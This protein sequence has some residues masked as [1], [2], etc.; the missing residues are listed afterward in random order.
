M[1]MAL[2]DRIA[3]YQ[4]VATA[5]VATFATLGATEQ[6]TVARVASVAVADEEK[7]ENGP[8]PTVLL[9]EKTIPENAAKLTDPPNTP[10][11]CTNC[12]RLEI[13]EIT[14]KLVSG[15]LYTAPGDY[16]DG[17]RR[18]PDGLKKCMYPEWESKAGSLQKK[19]K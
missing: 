10:K 9:I 5:T 16:P 3:N 14:G 19:Q 4:P 15:C 17:W 11:I 8:V 18:L 7:K 1:N 6:L 12:E 13:V 2:H